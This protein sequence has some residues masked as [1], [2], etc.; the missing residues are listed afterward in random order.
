MSD[1]GT[2]FP[3]TPT[4]TQGSCCHQ[5]RA[6]VSYTRVSKHHPDPLQ[7]A[8][9][10]AAEGAAAADGTDVPLGGWA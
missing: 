4:P 3:P 10:A 7:K 2:P 1:E 6:R 9:W 5:H 8:P